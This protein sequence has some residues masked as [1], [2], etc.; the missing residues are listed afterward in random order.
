MDL[1]GILKTMKEE[2]FLII[3]NNAVQHLCNSGRM[4]A[5]ASAAAWTIAVVER[6]IYLQNKQ[7]LSAQTGDDVG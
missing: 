5:D 6:L 7:D 4:D 2:D 3:K 1:M